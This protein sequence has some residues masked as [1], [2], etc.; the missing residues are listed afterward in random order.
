MTENGIV[1]DFYFILLTQIVTVC[2]SVFFF[3]F[4]DS[5]RHCLT[6]CSFFFS[7]FLFSWL[8]STLF[9]N[10]FLIFLT[11]IDA[12]CYFLL[13]SLFVF[14]WFSW[15]RSTL[16]VILFFSW[17]RSTLF[18]ILFSISFTQIDTVS[19]SVFDFLDSDRLDSARHCLLFCLLFC[20]FFFVFFFICF[21]FIILFSWLRSTLSAIPC[22]L[23]RSTYRPC[24]LFCFWFSWLRS[25]HFAIL[26]L[27]FLPQ[28]QTVCNFGF[29]F[30]DSETHIYNNDHVNMKILRSERL[31]EKYLDWVPI[32]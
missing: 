32:K 13:L 17:L 16:F 28:F 2:Y 5:E 7:F 10:L 18:S 31:K 3:N 1:Y 22:F 4:L 15:L 26:F 11:Q 24:L 25:T 23:L 29:D 27:I 30:L 14:D 12:V 20:C 8:W 19:Y 9:A 21:F 6:V